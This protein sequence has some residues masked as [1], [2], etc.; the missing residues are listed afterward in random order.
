MTRKQNTGL[1]FFIFGTIFFILGTITP[2]YYL[3]NAVYSP[4]NTT[5]HTYPS[6]KLRVCFTPPRG[7]SHDILN[8]ISNAKTTI[9]VQA[10]SF[11]SKPIAQALIRAKHNGVGIKVLLDKSQLT[12]RGSQL[13]ALVKNDIPVHIERIPG[14]AHNKVI[15]IDDQTTITG[16][17]NFTNAA[18]TRN[19]ENVLFILD[20]EITD[21]YK[22]NWLKRFSVSQP[23]RRQF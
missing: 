22:Q 9:Y 6:T 11:T 23:L 8:A 17:Y 2:T 14:L 1:N 18:E 12:A 7:C 21:Q 4:P 15:I 13:S 3:H 20:E 10:Y 19:A 16:S 5:K